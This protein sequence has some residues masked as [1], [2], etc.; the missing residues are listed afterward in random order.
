MLSK[1][2][3]NVGE[4]GER[5]RQADRRRDAVGTR[6]SL[7]QAAD[8]LDDRRP[9]RDR[10]RSVLTSRSSLGAGSD[11]LTDHAGIIE[12]LPGTLAVAP[13][14]PGPVRLDE[15]STPLILAERLSEKAG[16]RSG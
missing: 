4:I 9:R 11:I 7:E 15:G 2:R 10:G 16:L 8:A 6:F 1:P 14:D 13:G 5:H 3:L 12:R